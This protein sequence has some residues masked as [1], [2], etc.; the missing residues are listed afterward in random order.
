MHEEG[1]EFSVIIDCTFLYT[2]PR[3][4]IPKPPYILAMCTRMVSVFQDQKPVSQ[5]QCVASWHCLWRRKKLLDLRINF[6]WNLINWYP[7]SRCYHDYVIMK[8]TVKTV[9]FDGELAQFF[10]D[11]I[12]QIF[13]VSCTEWFLIGNRIIWTFSYHTSIISDNRQIK[14]KQQNWVDKWTIAQAVQ[15]EQLM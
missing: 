3:Y 15:N 7:S 11:Q 12:R 4:V 10:S 9:M 1:R 13:A 8:F 2:L 14:K 6:G 5:K